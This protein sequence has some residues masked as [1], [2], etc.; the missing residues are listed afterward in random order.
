[1]VYIVQTTPLFELIAGNNK[2]LKLVTQLLLRVFRH[3]TSLNSVNKK[4]LKGF[5]HFKSLEAAG[6]SV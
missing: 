2:L 4:G 5:F 3:A 1:M 6:A